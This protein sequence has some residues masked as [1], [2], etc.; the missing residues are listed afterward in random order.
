M[1]KIRMGILDEIG[2]QMSKNGNLVSIKNKPHEHEYELILRPNDIKML[3]YSLL[4]LSNDI[5]F[6]KKRT[7]HERSQD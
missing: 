1:Q 4:G 3:A 7:I 6:D 5:M 2:I